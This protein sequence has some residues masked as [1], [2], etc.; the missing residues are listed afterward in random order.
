[1]QQAT[2]K[3]HE[4]LFSA[5]LLLQ[6]DKNAVNVV[7][8]LTGDT[9]SG[10][11]WSHP[12]ARLIF[13]VLSE[14]ADQPDVLFAKLLYGRVTLIHRKLWPALLAV[15]SEKQPW[16]VR[17]LSA[18]AL[19]LLASV[20][21]SQTPVHGTGTAVKELERRL[22]VHSDEV[23]SETGRHEI[24]LQPWSAWARVVGTKPMRSNAAARRQIEAAAMGIGA[25]P[26]ALPWVSKSISAA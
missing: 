13:A 19:R 4:A 14:L 26:S 16:Q 1:M 3:V 11:W 8:L 15:A 21:E 18:S 5:G 10:S 7:A 22:L 25:K 17:G 23:H 2:E 12:K 9:L 20:N 24:M 6:Q